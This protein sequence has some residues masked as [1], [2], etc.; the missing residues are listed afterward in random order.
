V[1]LYS[2][3]LLH[4]CKRHFINFLDDDGDDD[5]YRYWK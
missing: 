1:T 3:V 5:D 4:P 2:A